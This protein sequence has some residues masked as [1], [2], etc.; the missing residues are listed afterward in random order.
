MEIIIFYLMAI[1]F[2]Y[3]AY[4]IYKRK[5]FYDKNAHELAGEV[6]S[7][8]KHSSNNQT[9]YNI[10]VLAEDGKTYNVSSSNGKAKKYKKQ[11]DIIIIVPNDITD[12]I[13]DMTSH[14]HEISENDDELDAE[15]IA[16][17][18]EIDKQMEIIGNRMREMSDK[19]VI[20]KEDKS[21]S[22]FVLLLVMGILF[23]VLALASTAGQFFH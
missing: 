22:D 9:V 17:L 20:I 2:I 16:M 11:R 7:F 8:E 19:L 1:L 5:K 15:K 23:A 13:E 4:H 6:I 18:N 14:L 12:D 3:G 21:L 10:E